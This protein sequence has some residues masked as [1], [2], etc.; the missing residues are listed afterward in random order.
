MNI[1]FWYNC[2]APKRKRKYKKKEVTANAF[3]PR[4]QYIRANNDVEKER[5]EMTIAEPTK[6]RITERFCIRNDDVKENEK[7]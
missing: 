1:Q 3:R 5:Q 7:R 6:R 2:Y 4:E